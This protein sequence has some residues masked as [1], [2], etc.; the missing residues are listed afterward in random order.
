MSLEINSILST[1][2]VFSTFLHVTYDGFN[3][4]LRRFFLP[5]SENYLREDYKQYIMDKSKPSIKV[6]PTY[7]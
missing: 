7:V 6:S 3:D 5:L 4:P 1:K 2:E